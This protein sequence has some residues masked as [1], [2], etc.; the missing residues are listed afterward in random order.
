MRS[1]KILAAVLLFTVTVIGQTNKGGISGTVSDF[2]GGAVP[3]A[4][5][6]ITNLG[7]NQT[8]TVTTTDDGSY[9]VSSLDP[10]TNSIT[11]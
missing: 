6:T 5:V 2:N 9:S 10:L 7:T 8:S 4:T 1:I 3:G 11:V